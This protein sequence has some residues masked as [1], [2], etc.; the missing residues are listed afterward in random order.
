M[1]KIIAAY[2]LT[3]D[4]VIDHHVST[5]SAEIHNYYTHLLDHSSYILWGSTTYKLM[6]YWQ[7]LLQ[8]PAE[9]AS[10]NSFAQAIDKI[11]KIVFSNK[12]KTTGWDSAKIADK[13]LADTV[14][15]LK[16][17]NNG[18]ILIGSRSL[19]IQLLNLGLIDELQLCMIPMIAASG[20][21]FFDKLSREIKLD[22]WKTRQFENG[23]ILLYYRVLN[24]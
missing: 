14:L 4:G 23:S 7:G 24:N 5:P 8:S 17:K 22:L 11:A 2:N 9:E 3:L 1:G 19:I 13:S 21:T 20:Q 15:K 10:M 6:R 12:E 16:S 18:D